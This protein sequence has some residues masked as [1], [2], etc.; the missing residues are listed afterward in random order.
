MEDAGLARLY[1]DVMVNTLWEGTVNALSHDLLRTF[2]QT[3]GRA[4]DLLRTWIMG[5]ISRA[6]S[7]PELKGAC[8]AVQEATDEIC[9]FAEEMMK[10]SSA[11]GKEVELGRERLLKELTL[12]IGKTVSGSLMVG[13]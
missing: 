3:S 2:H 7:V 13:C 11:D 9:R 5:R 12:S 6:A 4:I 1:R 10:G 8:V